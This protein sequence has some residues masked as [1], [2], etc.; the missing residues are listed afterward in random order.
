MKRFLRLTLLLIL[1]INLPQTSATDITV[2]FT[3]TVKE[4]TCAMTLAPLNGANLSGDSA[5]ENYLLDLPSLGV[6]DI[7]NKS[8]LTEASFKILPSNCSNYVSSMSMTI[9]G[10]HSGYTDSL[11]V[12][13]ASVPNGVSYIGAGFKRM[14]DDDSLRF[15]LD[16]TT[17]IN[18]TRDEMVNGLNL[19]SIIRQTTSSYHMVPGELQVKATFVFTYN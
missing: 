12:N 8:S 14:N 19:T 18:W 15:K 1:L 4:T 9:S 11:L 7:T 3:A 16:G 2:N 10:Q 5:T 17:R 13:V 6:S